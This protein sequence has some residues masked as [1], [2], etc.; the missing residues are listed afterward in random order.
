MSFRGAVPARPTRARR[1]AATKLHVLL[2]ALGLLIAQGPVLLHLLLVSHTTCEHGELVELSG[3]VHAPPPDAS[4]RRHPSA[5]V[6]KRGNQAD[7]PLLVADHAES[8]G[9]DHCDALAVRQLVPELAPCVA[10]ASLLWIEPRAL[11]GE[12]GETRSVPLLSL[13]PKSSPP[14]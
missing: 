14:V 7:P 8:R 13:A 10:A 3:D 2:I 9:H 1:P 4:N 5:P 6:A 11:R 12:R